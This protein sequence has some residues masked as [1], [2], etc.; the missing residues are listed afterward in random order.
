MVLTVDGPQPQG[1]L[2]GGAEL[3]LRFL[4]LQFLPPEY[5]ELRAS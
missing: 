5:A 1:T 2:S 4:G 3:R